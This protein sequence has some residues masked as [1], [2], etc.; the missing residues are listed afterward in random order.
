MKIEP[1]SRVLRREFY[2]RDAKSVAID[3]LGKLLVRKL[4]GKIL[5]GIITETEAYFGAEDP[6][7]RAYGG[8]IKPINKWMWGEGGTI[9]IYMVHA[10]WLFNVITDRKAEPSGV[11]IRGIKPL[12]GVEEMMTNRGK[13]DLKNLTNGPGKLS[14]ALLIDKSMNG[15][16]IYDESSPIAIESPVPPLNFDVATSNRIGVSRDLDEELRFYIDRLGAEGK[17]R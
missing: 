15:L 6:A 17:R 2:L 16:K 14:K 13:T 3:L 11:L 12:S 7:S 9:F 4:N 8:K 1:P 10:N 5:S